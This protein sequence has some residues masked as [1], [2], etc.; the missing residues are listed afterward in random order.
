MP[1]LNF[2]V[3][4]KRLPQ[5]DPNITCHSAQLRDTLAGTASGGSAGAPARAAVMALP[6]TTYVVVTQKAA[7]FVQSCRLP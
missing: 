4:G 6:A 1:P 7:L 5:N 2:G 3:N